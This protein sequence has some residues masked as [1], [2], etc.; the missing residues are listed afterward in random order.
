MS[1]IVFCGCCEVGVYILNNLLADG[2]Q[3]DYIISLTPEQSEKFCISGYYDYREIASEHQIKN[4]IPKSY[5]LKNKDDINFF[6]SNNFDLMIQGGWQRLFPSDVLNTLSIGAIGIHPSP[7]LLPKGRGRSPLN[8]S[9]IQ[10][11]KRQLLHIFLISDGVDDG[12]IIDYEYFEINSFDNIKTLYYKNSIITYRLLKNNLDKILAK[13]LVFKKQIG[14]ASYFSKRTPQDSRIL[15]NEMDVTEIYNLVRA[16][17]R[18]YPGAFTSNSNNNEKMYIWNA[19]IFDHSII[20]SD[21]KIGEVVEIF[22]N[23]LIINC[24]GG[25]LLVTDFDG[26]VSKND[27]LI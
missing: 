24:L 1:K 27:I 20:Y 6:K 16:S 19:Q 17:T 26:K 9:L 14:D 11:K 23:D 4:Y 7:D 8:W 15:W 18:P 2:V 12:E 22:D 5:N 10:N 25:L 3:I 13:N 21:S